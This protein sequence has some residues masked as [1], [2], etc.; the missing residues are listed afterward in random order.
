MAKKT[1]DKEKKKVKIKKT[2]EA[3][4]K[5]VE[6]T[7]ELVNE[8]V[9]ASSLPLADE[10][11]SEVKVDK[12][13][14]ETVFTFIT[15]NMDR[16]QNAINVSVNTEE[17]EKVIEKSLTENNQT[18]EEKTEVIVNDTKPVEKPKKITED[19]INSEDSNY[20]VLPLKPMKRNPK[21]IFFKIK[22]KMKI[23]FD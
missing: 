1:N 17:F 3:P 13:D 23:I 10:F 12:K 14:D 11:L 22:E 4:K 19:F 2:A 16:E 9:D 21:N 20:E 6:E 18:Y 5:N 7:F 15:E 8:E